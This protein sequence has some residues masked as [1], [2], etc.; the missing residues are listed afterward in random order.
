[1]GILG[2][3]NASWASL[4]IP[5]AGLA[6]GGAFVG[7]F[8]GAEGEVGGLDAVFA[9]L[10]EFFDEG[11]APLAAGTGGEAFADEAGNRGVFALAEVDDLALGDV[12]A[13]AYGVVVVHGGIVSGIG[14]RGCLIRD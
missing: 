10:V 1:M 11:D 2:N 12:E 14:G 9:L 13:E 7:V 8:F 4:G 5:F 6:V 3:I